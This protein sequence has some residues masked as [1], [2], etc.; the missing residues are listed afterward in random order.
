M[1]RLNPGSR[2]AWITLAWRRRSRVRWRQF[3]QCADMLTTPGGVWV[4]VEG[5]LTGV[6][7]S[8]VEGSSVQTEMDEGTGKWKM[9]VE[10]DKPYH[11]ASLGLLEAQSHIHTT[12][13]LLPHDERFCCAYVS[14]HVV[15]ARDTRDNEGALALLLLEP[16]L[17]LDRCLQEESFGLVFG[18]YNDFRIFVAILVL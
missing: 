11:G 15:T 6:G 13:W 4:E 14:G 18:F 12:A 7:G 5:I 1:K 17:L 2:L 9:R 8:S 16:I 10:E 3:I